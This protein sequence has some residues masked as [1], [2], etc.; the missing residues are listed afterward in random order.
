[1]TSLKLVSRDDET[2]AC[3]WRLHV[4]PLEA[5]ILDQLPQRLEDLLRS[6]QENRR[7]I[8][9]LF[10][11]SY[12]DPEEEREN[13]RLLGESLFDARKVML[14]EVRAMLAAAKREGEALDLDL[15]GPHVDLWLRFLNDA[16][17]V[18]ATD[19]GIEKNIGSS[20]VDWSHPRAPQYA[21]L[22]YLGA[23]EALI[24][25]AMAHADGFDD[26]FEC[27]LDDDDID[28]DD[29][30]IDDVDGI[31]NDDSFDDEM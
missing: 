25:D 11:R 10:P 30:D 16:R 9:R 3:H 2:G 29:D 23:V 20:K 17:L 15:D 27:D 14:G 8:D 31:E 13:R 4:P 18:V 7:I 6:P 28:D 24:L 5:S 22:E 12:E 21:L 1:M 26:R 19:L